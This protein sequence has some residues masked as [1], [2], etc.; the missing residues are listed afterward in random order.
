MTMISSGGL[1]GT[2]GGAARVTARPTPEHDATGCAARGASSFLD[3]LRAA[4]RVAVTRGDRG[5]EP[6]G[7]A[8][9]AGPAA[10][11]MRAAMRFVPLLLTLLSLLTTPA[12]TWFSSKERVLVSSEP[13]GARIVV[14]GYDTGRTTP[15]SLPLGGL[16]GG[17]HTIVLHKK[18]YRPAA[19]R[20]CQYTE[21][22][23]S[24]WIDGAY[25]L[26]MP[27]LPLF[28]TGGD[29]L[30]PFGVRA[31]IIP[32]ELHVVLERDDAP[33]LGFDLLAERRADAGVGGP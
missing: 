23:T 5:A 24:K 2:R 26:V 16:F 28:W 4:A 3:L 29:L 1:T 20:V 18:G 14:D 11:T 6:W 25:D 17:D 32:A 15:A 33:R 31:A 7:N 27:P 12:C 22:Y 21:G 9:R 19:R 10:D 30:T 13:L 8:A